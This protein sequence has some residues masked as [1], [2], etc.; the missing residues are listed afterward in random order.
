M[1]PFYGRYD[2]ADIEFLKTLSGPIIYHIRAAIKEY[3]QKLKNSSISAS[4][5]KKGGDSNG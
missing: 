3:V 1:L 4:A 2:K 5:S